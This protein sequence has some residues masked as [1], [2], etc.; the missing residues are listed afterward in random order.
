M[1]LTSNE[2]VIDDSF[3]HVFDQKDGSF[4]IVNPSDKR[5]QNGVKFQHGNMNVRDDNFTVGIAVRVVDFE[6]LYM[7]NHG[8]IPNY[9]VFP[10]EESVAYVGLDTNSF[11]QQPR[12]AYHCIYDNII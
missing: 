7:S 10:M 8:M 9:N 6:R 11:E 1:I 12:A 4:L 5:G 2:F 3:K